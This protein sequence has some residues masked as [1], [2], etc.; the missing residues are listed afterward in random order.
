[1]SKPVT[2]E[3]VEDVLS[4]IRRLVSE[5]R[6]PLAGLRNPAPQQSAEPTEQA[7]DAAAD[8]LVLT[9]ALRVAEP[10]READAEPAP[11]DLGSVARQTWSD[12]EGERSATP[13]QR[14]AKDAPEIDALVQSTLDAQDALA[15][16]HGDYGD[17]SYWEVDD[18]DR[19]LDDG[20]TGHAD[21]SEDFDAVG[22][23]DLYETP[24]Q[25]DDAPTAAQMAP[26]SAEEEG[27]SP[28]DET[29][30]GPGA[31][32]AANPRVLPLTAKIAALEAAVDKSKQEFEPDGG[33]DGALAGSDVPAMAWED[34]TELDARGA[35]LRETEER[36]LSAKEIDLLGD[37]DNFDFSMI[38]KG[39]AAAKLETEKPAAEGPVA[40][41]P[42]A[43]KPGAEHARVAPIGSAFGG[44]EQLMDEEALRDLVSEIVRAELQGALGER[45]TRN[46]RKLVRREIHRALTAQE[47][48]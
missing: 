16:E 41:K 29:A 32:L 12:P 8:R 31:Q 28:E 4:S 30:A 38:G 35:P 9:P 33:E 36:P 44:D 11:L 20:L 43:E 1:M 13:D 3:E 10:T 18:D 6:R 22:P 21:D 42:A 46:V 45:I 24:A 2:N 37:I 15:D 47:L 19:M 27:A 34:D 5:D 7:R 48:E 14:E 26:A 17:E 25:R 40:E 39:D 23:L